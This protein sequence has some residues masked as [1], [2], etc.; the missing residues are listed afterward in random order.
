MGKRIRFLAIVLV[1]CLATMSLCACGAAAPEG[2]K[3]LWI[4]TEQSTWDRMNGQL[5]VLK[6]AYE[7]EHDG[8]TIRVDCLP[9]SAQ[10]RDVYLQQLRTE[11]L[12]GGGPDCYLLPT[13]N[14]LIL[15]EPVADTYVQIDPLF[16]DVELAMRNGLFSDVTAYY[17]AD[18]DLDK[19]GLNQTIMDAGVLDG[20]R[21]V[22]PLRYDMP[23]I[24]ALDE[25]LEAAGL[26]PAILTQDL[27]TIMEAVLR[28]GDPLLAC[29]LLYEGYSAFS[30]F[31]DYRSGNAALDTDTLRRYLEDYQ[32]LTALLGTDYL[33]LDRIDPGE[34]SVLQPPEGTTVL[35]N[36]DAEKFIQCEYEEADADTAYVPLWIGSMQDVFDYV[37][38]AGYADAALTVTPLRSIGSGEVVA[39]VT[40]YAAVGSGCGDPALAYDFLRQFLLEDSQWEQNRPKR[41]HTRPVKGTA[42]NTSN[43]LQVRGLIENGW[44]VRDEVSFNTLWNVRRM[45]LYVREYLDQFN[46]TPV[47]IRRRMRRIG[48]MFIADEDAPSFR[49]PIGQV[50]FNTTMSD[51]LADAL[52]Q[53][54]DAENAPVPTDLNKLAQQLIWELRWHVSEG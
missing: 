7:Q 45:Q 26:D 44:P 51:V 24:I 41:K 52:A 25:A 34:R 30:G 35:E 18:D 3:E 17:D 15:D 10:E 1:L 48:L 16:P 42:S 36:L 23:V 2:P 9:V 46:P 8:V 32:Q 43:D 33:D 5:E 6:E 49:V 13:G 31:I 38:C 19:D 21:Y 12:R 54:N 14:T 53:L 50:R 39:T 20:V 27:C 22:L 47:E 40:Y 28:T 29:G 37:T 11:I 4:V